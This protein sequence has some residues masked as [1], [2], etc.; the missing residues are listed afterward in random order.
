MFKMFKLFGAIA[1]SFSTMTAVNAATISFDSVPTNTTYINDGLLLSSND[2]YSKG[3]CGNITP[4]SNGCLG[5]NGYDGRLVFTFVTPGTVT[6]A[7]INAFQVIMCEGCSG[8]PTTGKVYDPTGALLVTIN[9]NTAAGVSRSFGYSGGNIGSLVFD[10]GFDAVQSISF[11]TPA[12]PVPTVP[13]PAAGLMLVSALAG[14]VAA[15]R[16]KS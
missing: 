10:L 9:M 4:G 13:V 3:G 12:A 2:G 15:R 1:L 14:L 6:Q 5:D 11:D 16:R 7:V 8:R